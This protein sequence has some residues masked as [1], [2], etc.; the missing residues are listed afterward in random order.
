MTSS[1]C[2][3]TALHSNAEVLT[4]VIQQLQHQKPVIRKKAA[5]CLGA[6]AATSLDGLLH[7]IVANLL[8]QVLRAGSPV[9]CGNTLTHRCFSIRSN[10]VADLDLVRSQWLWELSPAAWVAAWADILLESCR[11]SC[12]AVATRLLRRRR[13]TATLPTRCARAAFPVSFQAL[14]LHLFCPTFL[15]LPFYLALMSWLHYS[16]QGLSVFFCAVRERRPR[17]CLRF[18]APRRGSLSTTLTSP[19]RMRTRMAACSW[20]GWGRT[21]TATPRLALT[22][23][24]RCHRTRMTMRTSSRTTAAAQKVC[25]DSHSDRV[26]AAHS[27][28]FVCVW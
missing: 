28:V 5:T 26:L 10:L 11:F 17:T 4:A 12:S 22:T 6:L 27:C 7:R 25:T 16:A 20:K 21:R 23:K 24:G 15:G 9:C 8:D 3:A 18:C 2:N 14:C 1:Q 13:S 19:T